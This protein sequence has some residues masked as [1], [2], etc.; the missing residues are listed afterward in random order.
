MLARSF[1][2]WLSDLRRA[3]NRPRRPVRR[4]SA[5]R[6][7]LETLGPR[8]LPSTLTWIGGDFLPDYCNLRHPDPDHPDPTS[9]TNPLNWQPNQVPGQND[10]V[11][12]PAPFTIASCP[13]GHG[14]TTPV[15]APFAASS[16]VNAAFGVSALTTAAAW[17]GQRQCE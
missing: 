4:R 12:F 11:V 16:N 15:T 8:D 14:G 5:C 9:W 3:L 2:R 6:L 10:T 17:G 1:P 7:F 13:D